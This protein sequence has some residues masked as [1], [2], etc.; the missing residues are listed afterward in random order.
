MLVCFPFMVVVEK[1]EYLYDD[2]VRIDFIGCS[3]H[4]FDLIL[5]M[6]IIYSILCCVLNCAIILYVQ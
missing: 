4:V 2:N 1:W 3:A 6:L 5:L